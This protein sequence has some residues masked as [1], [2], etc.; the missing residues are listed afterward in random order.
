MPKKLTLFR[1][2]FRRQLAYFRRYFAN[3]LGGMLTLYV[4]FLLILGGYRGLSGPS[5]LQ[6]DTTEA[7]VVGYG[8]WFYMLMTY[9]DVSYTIRTEAL[10]GTLEQLY[11]SIHSFGWVMGASVSAAFMANFVMWAVLLGVAMFTTGTALNIDLLSVLPVL[12]GTL[13]GPLGIGFIIGGLTLVFKRIESYTQMVQF[14]LIGLVAVPAE[15]VVWM[16]LLP[17]SFG[18]GL[19]RDIMVRGASLAE[20]GAGNLAL[21]FAIG[22]GHL[23]L[24]Y[25][26][27]KQCE[28]AAMSRGLL[29]HY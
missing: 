20:I 11:M 21:L 8:L 6:G 22:V 9:Q 14:V 13:L 17:G 4:V 27:Y 10:T 3:S 2:F 5:G 15:R 24:G 23:L 26:V 28:R 7:L 19:V 16:R 29:G 18:A 12:I 25:A 1:A